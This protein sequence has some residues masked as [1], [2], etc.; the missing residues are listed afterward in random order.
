[1]LAGDQS[2]LRPAE[3]SHLQKDLVPVDCK[4]PKCYAPSNAQQLL[5]HTAACSSAAG[6]VNPVYHDGMG[7]FREGRR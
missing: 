1:M 4:S 3:V 2:R 5:G 6:C 7:S